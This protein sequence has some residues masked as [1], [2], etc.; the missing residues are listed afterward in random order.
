MPKVVNFVLS[1][2]KLRKQPI[3]AN[4]FKIHGDKDPCSLFRRPVGSVF[5]SICLTIWGFPF[6]FQRLL[7]VRNFTPS[8]CRLKAASFSEGTFV[9]YEACIIWF[10]L[11]YAVSRT[12]LSVQLHIYATNSMPK[13]VHPNTVQIKTKYFCTCL[14]WILLLLSWC[15]AVYSISSVYNY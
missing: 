10:I 11:D 1:H 4:I 13:C 8:W 6:T 9:M 7:S 5:L 12:K 2:S 15:P 3:F 14:E